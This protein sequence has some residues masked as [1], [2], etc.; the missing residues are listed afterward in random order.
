VESHDICHDFL[1]C[2]SLSVFAF[3]FDQS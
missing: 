1:R 2:F 3:R